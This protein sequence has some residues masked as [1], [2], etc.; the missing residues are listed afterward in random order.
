LPVEFLLNIACVNATKLK[1]VAVVKEYLAGV[2]EHV[3]LTNCTD[4]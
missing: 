4:F 3:N 2:V 1:K